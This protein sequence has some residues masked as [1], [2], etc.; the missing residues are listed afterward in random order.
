[1][2]G[3]RVE[4]EGK[5]TSGQ[6]SARLDRE[7]AQAWCDRMNKEYPFLH[8]YVVLCDEEEAAAAEPRQEEGTAAE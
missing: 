1:M 6:G 7:T 8:H 4:W 3:Y 2:E 5:H